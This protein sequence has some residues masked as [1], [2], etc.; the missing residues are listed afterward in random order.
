MKLITSRIRCRRYSTAYKIKGYTET[1]EDHFQ[2][3]YKEWR[4][5]GIFPIWTKELFFEEIPNYAILQQ[6][7]FGET[8]W[9]SAAPQWMHDE[10]N[11]AQK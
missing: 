11:K 4:L 5:F 10:V 3:F 6:A 8:T 1:F 2:K 9:K 7:V